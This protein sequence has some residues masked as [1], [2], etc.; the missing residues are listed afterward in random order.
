MA[1]QPPVMSPL[2]WRAVLGGLPGLLSRSAGPGESVRLMLREH[3]GA[4]DVVLLDGGTSALALALAGARL[5]APD[6]PVA[7]PAYG[8]FD[9]ATAAEAGG[10]RVV[11]YDTDPETLGPE[12]RSL[13]AALAATPSAVVFAHLYGVPVDVVGLAERVR[14]CGALVVEDAAQ[15]AGASLAGRPTGSFGDVSVLSF[16]RGKGVTGGGGGALLAFSD[17]GARILAAARDGLDGGGSGAKLL[18][19]LAAQWL[20]GRPGL[21]RLP[22][23]LPFLRLGETIYRPPHVPSAVSRASVRVVRR[24]WPLAADDVARRRRNAARLLERQGPGLRAVHPPTSAAPSW[25]RLPMLASPAVRGRVETAEARSLG[26][27]GGYPMPLSA[28]PSLAPRLLARDEAL[29]GARRLAAELVTIPTHAGLGE[30]DVLRLEQW[31][32]SMNGAAR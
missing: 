22:A 3:F 31:M 32:E 21:Y 19:L 25:L 5:D 16:G 26:V 12:P 8:C 10:A 17:R 9:I 6:H 11:L 27:L 2:P 7:L 20:L 23:S 28:L 24:T 30:S 4:L 14:A 1:F 29:P 15:G 13:Q 18:A